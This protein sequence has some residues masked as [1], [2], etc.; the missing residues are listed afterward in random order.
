MK[1]I[2]I[3]NYDMGNLRSVK[4]SLSFLGLESLIIDNKSDF[5]KCS[6]Y[7]LPGVGAFGQGI[8]NLHHK[9]FVDEIINQV[10]F[11]KKSI[12]G[13]C[14]GM[15]LLLTRSVEY[16]EH[17]GL[18]LINGH[19]EYLG[20]KVVDLPLPH[21]GWNDI[22]IK[23]KSN[24]LKSLNDTNFY[25][26]HNYYCSITDKNIVTGTVH[27]NFDFDVVLEQDNIYGCQFHPEKSHQNGM[28][29]LKN[30]GDL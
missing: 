8:A 29:I 16:G 2:G 3:I 12:L 17:K 27:Y 18:N 30:F 11:K 25:F 22:M 6:K 26:V 1:M 9:G 19:V 15:Q 28:Q 4:N 21:M 20:D 23:S 13:I 10:V 24:L 7:I 5:N 14:L